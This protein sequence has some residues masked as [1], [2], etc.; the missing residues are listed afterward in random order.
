MKAHSTPRTPT[1]TAR[2][3]TQQPTRN[4]SG[5][6]VPSLISRA[7]TATTSVA[8]NYRGFWFAENPKL[9]GYYGPSQYKVRLHITNPL[10][11]SEEEFI[12]HKPNGPSFWAA[13]AEQAGHDSVIIQDIIDGDTESTVCC[14][15]DSHLIEIVDKDIYQDELEEDV[16]TEKNLPLRKGTVDNARGMYGALICVM[17]PNDF[18]RLTTGDEQAFNSIFSDDFASLDDY[19]A[20]THPNYNKSQYNMPWLGVIYPSGEVVQH[21]GR[22]RAAMVAKAGGRSFPCTLVFYA[23]TTWHVTY[24]K[25]E[26]E[27]QKEEFL[28]KDFPTRA[29]ANEFIEKL[30]SLNDDPDHPYSYFGIKKNESGGGK[31]KGSPRSDPSKWQFAPWRPSD[32]PPM[33]VGQFNSSIRIP[34]NRMKFGVVKGY[35]HYAKHLMTETPIDDWSVDPDF[36]QNE[37]EMIGKFTGYEQERK[38][39]PDADKAGIRDET[40]IKRVKDAF[41]KT[42]THFNLYFW[43]SDNPNYDRTLQKGLRDAAWVQEKLGAKAAEYVAQTASPNN[44][45]II[46]TNNLSDE[47]WISIRSPWMMAH[48]ISHVLMDGSKRIDAS[49]AASHEF[50]Q[51]LYDV[52]RVGYGLKWPDQ[53]TRYGYVMY[54]EWEEIYMKLMGTHLGTMASARNKKLVQASEWKHE[55]FAQYLLTGKIT[56]NPLPQVFDEG[57]ELTTDPRKLYRVNR[58]WQVFPK[59]LMRAFDE[60]LEEAKGKIWVM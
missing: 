28:E 21:E 7:S 25:Y 29:A 48:R 27:S 16:V 10:I 11:V 53:E 35:S 20:G 52:L 26:Y 42:P 1:S 39:W 6:T 22:H 3:K 23:P 31:L 47:S 55:T 60:L 24:E 41:S 8:T 56:L 50:D 36:D 13:K 19:K 32:A 30:E 4:R 34:T 9:T 33:L 14:V 37:K 57:L 44:V 45:T 15:F 12:A 40:V 59:R 5:I 2:R 17:D 38:H 54:Q 49:Y 46:M 58:M 51:F 18:I 43:Q